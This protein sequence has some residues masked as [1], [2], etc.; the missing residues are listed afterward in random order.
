MFQLLIIVTFA[1][2]NFVGFRLTLW[3]LKVKENVNS[4][5]LV[6]TGCFL[7]IQVLS[8][9]LVNLVQGTNLAALV[10][11]IVAFGFVLRRFL[12]LKLWQLVLIPIGVSL[13][14]SLVLGVTFG[15]II[16]L[17]GPIRVS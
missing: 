1:F 16:S 7:L 6:L 9:F 8:L 4:R 2:G 14:S 10:L 13:V 3:L 12:I 15:L 5:S 11:S 17:F